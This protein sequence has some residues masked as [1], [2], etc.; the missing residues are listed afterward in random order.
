MA[1]VGKKFTFGLV[2]GFSLF[3]CPDKVCDIRKSAQDALK[4]S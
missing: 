2:G 1:H 4:P 3:F